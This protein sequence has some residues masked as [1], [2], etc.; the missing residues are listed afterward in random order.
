MALIEMLRMEWYLPTTTCSEAFAGRAAAEV[1]YSLG[2]H[3]PAP[4]VSE[5]GSVVK[6]AVIHV[7]GDRGTVQLVYD[8][9][10]REGEN[11]FPLTGSTAVARDPMG[12]SH[13]VRKRG[14]WVFADQPTG[15]YSPAGRKAVAM[16]RA[17]LSGRTVT[18]TEQPSPEPLTVGF[19]ANGSSHSTFLGHEGPDP[20]PWYVTSGFSVNPVFPYYELTPPFD[21]E[22]NPQGEVR[23]LQAS[24]F[25]GVE[26][27]IKLVSGTPVVT[28][29]SGT[30][31]PVSAPGVAG[32]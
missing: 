27:G 2:C 28:E 6:K 19:C 12:T 11:P 4:T 31:L 14:R 24:I 20:W 21:T 18:V 23:L 10:C 16:L 8:F 3:L 9:L 5:F 17:A 29:L 25:S 13:W 15:T 1:K 22:G 32:C 7:R 26:W 30:S